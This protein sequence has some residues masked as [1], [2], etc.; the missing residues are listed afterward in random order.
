MK[1]ATTCFGDPSGHEPVTSSPRIAVNPM[2]VPS[3]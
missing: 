1:S 2:F 3:K